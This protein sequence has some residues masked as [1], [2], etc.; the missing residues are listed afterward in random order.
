MPSRTPWALAAACLA[1]VAAGVGLSVASGAPDLAYL[2]VDAVVGATYPLIGALIAARHPRHPVAWLFFLGGGGLALQALTGGYAAVG[3]DAG[4][5][6]AG[7]AAWI[8]NWI[9]FAGLGPLLLL[10]VLVPD[11]RLP[12]PRWRP[13]VAALAAAIAV[14]L[15][16]LMLRDRIWVWG[17]ETANPIGVVPT[18]TVIAPAFAAVIVAT[19]GAAVVALVVRV[20]RDADQRR[21]LTPILAAAVLLAAALA[22]DALLPPHSAVGT[23]LMAL[24]LP[25]LPV[26]TAVSIFRHRLFD[27]E[28]YVRRTVVFVAVA[29]VL[30][31]VYLAIVATFHTLLGADAGVVVQLLATAV[32]AVAFAPV[33]DVAQRA[34]ARVLFGDRGDPASALASLGSRLEASADAGRLLDGAAETVAAT[35]RLPA[36]A[37]LDADG[38]PVSASG[39]PRADALRVPLT[40]GGQFE[41]EL[42]AAP[43]SPGERLSPADV[44]VL[45]GLGRHLAVA[46]AASRLSREVQASR[47]RLVAAREEERRYLRRELHDGLGP[48]LAAIGL[49]LDVL[50]AKAPPELGPSIAA[51]RSLASSLVADV[52]R[53]VHD[54]RPSAL[55]ELGLVGALEDLALRPDRGPQVTVRTPAGALPP[56]PAAVEV[57]AYRIVQEAL[58][59]ALRH[60]E[61]RGVEITAEASGRRLVLTVADDG[62]G[63]PET[64]REGVGSGSMRE[65]AAEL[66]GAL[67]RAPR[68]GGGTIV[69]AELPLGR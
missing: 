55:D 67:R 37:I 2:G 28:V 52:R 40:S 20:R 3:L 58:A 65:R 23:T 50:E 54:L 22:T 61:A 34:V 69:E 41:G 4:W 38:A 30:L 7:V 26:A 45:E 14:L 12:S 49:R 39:E 63:M 15:V 66:G 35:L 46:L 42:L 44:A 62:R 53:M 13:A 24:A 25:L 29:A 57:A 59:N 10:P 36:V 16:L 27:I 8:A 60:S 32:V 33:R 47:E 1:A 17:L 9:F 6:G 68:P 56:L 5:P 43:R 51:V 18:D 48:G 21:R 31:A 11:G 19:A 64:V